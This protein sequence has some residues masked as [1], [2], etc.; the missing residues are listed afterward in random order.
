MVMFIPNTY[1]LWWNTS[2]E[3]FISRMSIEYKAFWNDERKKK[4][5]SAGL[6]Q[7][8][9][10][11]LASII[12]KETNYDPEK[13]RIAG[14]FINRLQKGWPL[15]ADPTLV[16]AVGDFE[17]KR[18]LNVHKAIESPYNTYKYKG[19]PPGPICLPSISSIDAVLNYEKH[20]Y[21]Y[22]CAKPDMSGSHNFAVTL[23]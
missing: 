11:I 20:H 2:A 10:S 22:F 4:A 6:T 3:Q 14:V 8:Q 13:A 7:V 12:E 17:L 18:I 23:T 15:Q 9:V 5:T 16:F 21:M 1:E 19:L